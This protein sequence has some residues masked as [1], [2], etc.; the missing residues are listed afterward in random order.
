MRGKPRSRD[1]SGI[2]R[3]GAYPHICRPQ[4]P[5]TSPG[6]RRG[7]RP[8][9]AKRISGI[10]RTMRKG[11]NYQ[12]NVA[13]NVERNTVVIA[14]NV[15]FLWNFFSVTFNFIILCDATCKTIIDRQS[16]VKNEK[17]F[18]LDPAIT[19]KMISSVDVIEK[20]TTDTVFEF[21]F[22]IINVS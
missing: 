21:R 4:D 19:D 6:R 5:G 15:M 17:Y 3:K 2:T 16:N 14:R 13:A 1:N 20:T 12:S 10:L 7:C 18:P 22:S 8:G 11:N 9:I